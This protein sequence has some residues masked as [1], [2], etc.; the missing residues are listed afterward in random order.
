[1]GADMRV[2]DVLSWIMV[3][4]LWLALA[5]PGAMAQ[6]ERSAGINVVT[7]FYPVYIMARNVL[8]DVPGVTVTNLTPPV[9]G[10]LH[11]YAV[12]TEDMRKLA[13]ADVFVANGAGMESFLDRVLAQYP[14]ISIV[15][16]AEGIPLIRGE[17]E[18]GYNPHV[19]VSISEVI[20][21]V[22]NLGKAM[23]EID[24]SRAGKYS[25]NMEEYAGKLEALREKMHTALAPYKG[26]G[27]ITFHEAFPYFAREFG[28]QILAVVARE[29]GS[30]PSARDLAD[31]VD[32]VRKAG[33]RHLFS[34]PQYPDS[35]ARV[36][37][38]ETGAAVH[39]LDPAV[40]GPDDPD[41]YLHIME[42]N[43]MVLEEAF[44]R[45]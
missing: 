38:R 11:D 4:V 37:A 7:S 10:C 26:S 44:A 39:V 19:W 9:T 8:K 32:L 45:P 22:R 21:Q 28:F 5:V 13:H 16:L 17:G 42:K 18:A 2:G 31:T 27:I 6:E 23:Q 1:M 30:E 25:G 34:E 41:A 15:Q 35:A 12:T 43:L 3:P 20:V 14:G 24:P 40:T 29:P 33:V 36:I